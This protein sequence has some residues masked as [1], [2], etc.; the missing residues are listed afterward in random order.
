MV[1]IIK[2]SYFHFKMIKL[3]P[4]FLFRANFVSFTAYKKNIPAYIFLSGAN[5]GIFTAK[6]NTPAYYFLRKNP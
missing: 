3:K 2:K 4:F 5:I 1:W 6:Q